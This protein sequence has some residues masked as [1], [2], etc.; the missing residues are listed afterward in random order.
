[1]LTS[2]ITWSTSSEIKDRIMTQ[3]TTRRTTKGSAI[4][5]LLYKRRKKE[6]LNNHLDN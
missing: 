2:L 4:M 1:M 6:S 5:H 3:T